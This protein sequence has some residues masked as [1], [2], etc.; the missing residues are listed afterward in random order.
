M[1][2]YQPRGA[3]AF[4]Q[5]SLYPLTLEEPT[6]GATMDA[7]IQEAYFGVGTGYAD[8]VAESIE[9]AKIEGT[10]IDE[11]TFYNTYG[12]GRKYEAGMTYEAAQELVNYDNERKQSQEV[13]AGATNGAYIAGMTTGFAAGVFEPKNLAYGVG[14]SL[15]ATPI[16]GGA[17]T[18]VKSLRRVQQL[19]RVSEMALVSRG[20]Y[21][22]LT[23]RGGA[24]GLVSAALMEPSNRYSAD[25]LQQDYTMADSLWNVA[26][27]AVLGAGLGAAPKFVQDKWAK[28]KGRTPDIITQ[29]IDV[30]TEQLITGQRVDV[31]PVER[32][33]AGDIAAKPIAEKAAA[34]ERVVRYTETPEF[35]SKMEGANPKMYKEG[36]P[37]RIYHGTN[38][39]FDKLDADG[40][41]VIWGSDSPDTSNSYATSPEYSSVPRV[42][43]FYSNMRNPLVVDAKGAD[44]SQIEFNRKIMDSDEIAAYAKKKGYDGVI[45]ENV[46]D[47]MNAEGRYGNTSYAIFKSENIIPAFGEGNID[48]IASRLD[49]ENKD[50]L[51]KSAAEAVSPENDT[52]ID[53][54]AARQIDEM[55]LE[56]NPEAEFKTYMDEVR[57]MRKDGLIDEAEFTSLQD[58]M[59]NLNE[60]DLEAIHNELYAC[61]TRG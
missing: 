49:A 1:I 41:R 2:P 56:D 40:E 12:Q 11:E 5:E 6:V 58:A 20:S 15:L 27:S 26:T 3:V 51:Q 9:L 60:A 39:V 37:V 4:G 48:T 14:T 33:E 31:T 36:A 10:P 13:I 8:S 50:A 23:A 25:I 54:D 7:F 22:A 57:Q 24:E 42:D 38:K 16:I 28:F 46:V 18:G 55:V 34:V 61:L 35:T 32:L 29:E 47:D 17:V 45:I 59:D 52:A 53:F 44:W 19:R 30:A 43:I 21:G